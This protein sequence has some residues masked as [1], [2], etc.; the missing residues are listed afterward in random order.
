MK[1]LR[2]KIGLILEDFDDNKTTDMNI[3]IDNLIN[4]MELYISKNLEKEIRNGIVEDLVIE[5][6][7]LK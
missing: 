1:E 6:R 2:K 3:Y 7:K 4:A 5:I